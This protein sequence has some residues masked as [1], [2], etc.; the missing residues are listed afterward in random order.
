MT[1]MVHKRVMILAG[2]IIAVFI[3]GTA[4]YMWLE[5]WSCSEALYMTIITISTVGFQEVRALSDA[6]R[7]FTGILILSGVLLIA[8]GVNFIFSSIIEGTFT[9]VFRRQRMDKKISSMT[10][11]FIICGLGVVGEDIVQEFIRT[12]GRFV[13]IEKDAAVLQKF[14]GEYPKLL[15]VTGDA[16]HDDKLK[17]A[18]IERAKGII[19]AL[20]NDADNLY[21]CLTARDLNP[22]LRIISRVLDSSSAD[23]MKKAGA[24]YVFSPEKI[25]GLH[26]ASA[27][28]RPTVMSFLDAIVRGEH[29]NLVLDEVTVRTESAVTGKTLRDSGISKNIGV[30]IPAI[31]SGQTNRLTFNPSSGTV[32]E[33]GDT[34]I[35]FGTPEQLKQL[36]KLCT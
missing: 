22:K 18:G 31:K 1:G 29:I 20:G 19:A 34:L 11:H 21:I 16:T 35:S 30:V 7:L 23:R 9:E 36:K 28:L 27:A 12:G 24:D 2:A 26:L 15:Y 33:A 6:G 10:D 32:I 13:L 17:C 14:I 25:G 3:A 8:T 5:G 4:G